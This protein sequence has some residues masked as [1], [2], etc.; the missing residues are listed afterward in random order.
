MKIPLNSMEGR[1]KTEF[2]NLPFI[3]TGKISS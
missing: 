3:K 1:K 2:K